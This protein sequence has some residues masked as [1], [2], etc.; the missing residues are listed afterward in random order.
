DY[1]RTRV[2]EAARNGF[3]LLGPGALKTRV[4]SV[5][6]GDSPNGMFSPLATARACG[7]H[8]E[9]EALGIPFADFEAG[10]DISFPQGCSTGDSQSRGQRWL[11]P[12]AS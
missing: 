11:P 9:A 4:F 12:A 1:E 6:Y 7:L 8:A 2:E 10:G 3:S 5:A